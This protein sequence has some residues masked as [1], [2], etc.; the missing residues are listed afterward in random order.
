MTQTTSKIYHLP[1]EEIQV[2]RCSN[3]RFIRKVMFVV[4]VAQPRQ[5]HGRKRMF[6]GKLGCWPLVEVV[7]CT[8]N[9]KNR[10]KGTMVTK[11]ITSV[12]KE[13]IKGILIDKLI[14]AIVEKYPRDCDEVIVQMDNASPHITNEDKDW[15]AAVKVSGIKIRIKHQ[16]PNSPDLNVL[17]LGYFNSIQSLQQQHKMRK[18]EDL[19]ESVSESYE[20]LSVTPLHNIWITWK[21]IMLKVIEVEGDNTYVLPHKNRSL[22][23]KF[24]L[25]QTNVVID[26]D[27]MR[28]IESLQDERQK[29]ITGYFPMM[30]RSRTQCLIRIDN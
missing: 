21:L 13:I 6:E 24:G 22:L 7:P 19:V 29:L 15:E 2:R 14:P 23:E 28:K 26:D 18:I 16:P 5:D 10:P 3:K 8:R 11:E 12:N 17:D 25:I 9:S 30:T 20:S 4:A 27:M 1:K